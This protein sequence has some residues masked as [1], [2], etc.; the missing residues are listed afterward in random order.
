ME[1]DEQILDMKGNYHQLEMKFEKFMEEKE[2]FSEI[3]EKVFMLGRSNDALAK[4][5]VI[6][7]KWELCC[8]T[9]T[10]GLCGTV[11]EHDIW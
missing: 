4:N 2:V 11:L 10:D 7:G 1:K 9:E 8:N 3:S 6:P 5:F